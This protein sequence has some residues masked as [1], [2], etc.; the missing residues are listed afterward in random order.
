MANQNIT[1]K[2]GNANNKSIRAK[3]NGDGTVSFYHAEDT[4]QR[5]VLLT[6][7]NNLA[8]DAKL[9]AV[10]SLLANPLTVVPH[11]FGRTTREYNIPASKRY[12]VTATSA[13]FALPTLGT[14]REVRL[15]PSS[16]CY[17]VFGSSTVTATT[18]DGAMPIPAD[19]G[20]VVVVPSGATH[21]AVIHNP[22]EGSV[23]SAIVVTPVA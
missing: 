10:R 17:I 16:R 11:P 19:A 8:T 23:D 12:A 21:I 5:T 15:M 9:E 2:D 4:D 6:V 13:A 1:V 22:A 7:L 3:D 18:A 14:T 20:E